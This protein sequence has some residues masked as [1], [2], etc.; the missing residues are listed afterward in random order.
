M[1]TK[2]HLKKNPEVEK[3]HGNQKRI[4]FP[5]D[6]RR[7]IA[8]FF[9]GCNFVC[10]VLVRTCTIQFLWWGL[11]IQ[12]FLGPG[13]GEVLILSEFILQ[14][15]HVHLQKKHT[16]EHPL[17]DLRPDSESQANFGLEQTFK[18]FK[19]IQ[20]KSLLAQ[21]LKATVCNIY[22]RTRLYV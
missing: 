12:A 7:L 8:G 11:P 17:P 2:L 22:G 15:L 4:K 20:N 6:Y 13:W 9:P 18:I 10:K 14:Y 16:L 1:P 21:S 3:L 19:N 5:I